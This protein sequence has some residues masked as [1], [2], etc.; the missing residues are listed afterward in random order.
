MTPRRYWTTVGLLLAAWLLTA[1]GW[2]ETWLQARYEQRVQQVH[3]EEQ[4]TRLQLAQDQVDA[5]MG[6]LG[7]PKWWKHWKPPKEE[8]R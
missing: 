3:W 6:R 7:L 4:E 5:L 2:R 1:W 8:R